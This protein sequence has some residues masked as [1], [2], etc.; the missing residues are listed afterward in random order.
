LVVVIVVLVALAGAMLGFEMTHPT[1]LHGCYAQAFGVEMM[2]FNNRT[3]CGETVSVAGPWSLVNNTTWTYRG[4]T[5][6]ATFLG[7][8]FSLIPWSRGEVGL[9]NVTVTEPS[10]TTYHAVKAFGGVYIP[11]YNLT[12]WF[13]PDHESGIYEPSF[14][15]NVTLLVEVGA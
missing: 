7:F 14:L 12:T 5:T 3:Y 11:N 6:N 4:T 1:S 8:A 15:E 2:T 9:L 10:G 13:A